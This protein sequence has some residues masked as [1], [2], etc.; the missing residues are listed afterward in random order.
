VLIARFRYI[1]H[2]LSE[3]DISHQQENRSQSQKP[4]LAIVPKL[5][6]LT[7]R[8]KPWGINKSQKQ[9]Q[10]QQ[11]AN[12]DNHHSRDLT[13]RMRKWDECDDPPYHTKYK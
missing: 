1:Q 5:K 8:T 13:K 9:I 7:N 4:K 2:H 3:N 6:H 10:D 12:Y 11:Q